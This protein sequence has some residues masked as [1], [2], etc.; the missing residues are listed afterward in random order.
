MFKKV[1]TTVV[2]RNM[3]TLVDSITNAALWSQRSVSSSRFAGGF[4]SIEENSI[5][6]E[7]G[8]FG[9]DVGDGLSEFIPYGDPLFHIMRKPYNRSPPLSDLNPI[10]LPNLATR[11]AVASAPPTSHR[12]LF[13]SGT[14]NKGSSRLLNRAQKYSKNQKVIKTL[15]NK[16]V[17]GRKNAPNISV[18]GVQKPYVIKHRSSSGSPPSRSPGFTSSKSPSSDLSLPPISLQSTP[19]SPCYNSLSSGI[20]SNGIDT[21]RSFK[22]PM[23][24]ARS[25]HFMSGKDSGRSS[26]RGYSSGSAR[27]VLGPSSKVGHILKGCGTLRV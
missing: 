27:E 20:S 13:L 7:D 15:P 6:M 4:S 24:S 3:T 14:L 26:F 11:S 17:G 18:E 1:W 16:P 9:G 10:S 12:Q 2:A 23:S 25:S 22:S 19:G 21:G 8:V 5:E